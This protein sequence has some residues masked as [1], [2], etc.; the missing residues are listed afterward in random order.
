M[1]L[2]TP[3]QLKETNIIFLEHDK[4]LKESELLKNQIYTLQQ[5]NSDLEKTDSLRIL[6]VN[7]C[8]DKNKSYEDT[9]KDLSS[10]TFKLKCF[11]I[12]TVGVSLA[13]ALLLIFK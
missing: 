6:Q 7:A 12:G 2:I 9:I 10:K 13:L 4:L 5:I 1:V 8:L 11:S 3:Q